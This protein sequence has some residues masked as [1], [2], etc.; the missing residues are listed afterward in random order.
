[1]YFSVENLVV[2]WGIISNKK[3]AVSCYEIENF[4]ITNHTLNVPKLES[5]QKRIMWE[6]KCTDSPVYPYPQCPLIF[7]TFLKL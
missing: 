4:Y 2:W 1:M 7:F 6:M 5:K 3:R